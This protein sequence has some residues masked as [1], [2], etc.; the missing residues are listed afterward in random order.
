ML[1]CASTPFPPLISPPTPSADEGLW[2]YHVQL[3][4][5]REELLI[6]AVFPKN[7]AE[8]QLPRGD[9][10]IR[11]LQTMQAGRWRPSRAPE[12]SAGCQ[13]RYRFDLGAA[14][15]AHPRFLGSE[16]SGETTITSLALWLL[17]PAKTPLRARYRLRLQSPAPFAFVSGLQER[18]PG[19]Y[20]GPAQM[21]QS[22]PYTVYGPLSVHRVRGLRVVL[23]PGA[24][25]L[26]DEALLGWVQRNLDLLSDYYRGFGPEKGLIVL[27]PCD[28]RG[29][30][31]GAAMGNGGAS[32]KLHVGRR[33]GLEALERDWTLP[34]ELVHLTFPNVGAKHRWLEEG[35]ATYVEPLARAQ[36]GA[37]SPEQFWGDLLKSAPGALHGE[38]LRFGEN[39][40]WS[41]TYW[42]GALFFLLADLQIRRT[43]KGQRTLAD[44]LVAIIKA[45]GDIQVYW[46]PERVYAVAD[47]AIGAPV[48]APLAAR[49]QGE[50]LGVDLPAVWEKLGVSRSPGTGVRF[51]DN[52]PWA[53]LRRALMTP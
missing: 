49:V 20:E 31:G 48:L 38:S 52:A 34:H 1:A 47:E 5:D 7:S 14:Q 53:H 33:A 4:P 16:R 8:L 27:L 12:C 40:S 21:L 15:S 22:P 45:G 23:Q 18:A 11:A 36:R 25:A 50:G 6:S 44:A 19:L 29:V 26:P 37:L 39:L 41:Q 17:R 51:D 30:H 28:H 32:L 3:D 24:W 13:V 42:G 46:P 35:L 9:R 43:T 10:F 2:S